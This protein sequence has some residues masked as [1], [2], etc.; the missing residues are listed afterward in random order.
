VH[1]YQVDRNLS[2]PAALRAFKNLVQKFGLDPDKFALHSMRVG[3]AT[4]AFHAAVP[5]HVIDKQGRWKSQYTKYRYFRSTDAEH[6]DSI[7]CINRY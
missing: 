6:V 4:D 5:P 2:Y 1:R 7:K 3:G